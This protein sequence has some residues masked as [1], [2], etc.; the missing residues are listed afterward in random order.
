[1]HV[2]G[3]DPETHAGEHLPSEQPIKPAQALLWGLRRRRDEAQLTQAVAEVARA[4]RRFAGAFVELLLDTAEADANGRAVKRL[5]E[6][7]VAK[8]FGCRA[9]E[10]LRDTADITLGRVD[11]RFDGGDVTLFV[12]NK[13]YSGYGDAQVHRYLEALNKLPEDRRSALV[14]ITRQVPTY[15][16]PTL[17]ADERWLGSVRWARMLKG[18][19]RLPVGD[20]ALNEQW[21]S[22]LDILDQ[23]GDLG[24]TGADPTLIQAWARY[25]EGRRHLED[26]LDQV[27]PRAFEVISR[28]LKAKYGRKAKGAE[29]AVLYSRGKKRQV[30]Q[31]D[32]TRVFF[33]CCIPAVVKDPVLIIQFSGYFG[34]PHFTVQVEPWDAERRLTDRQDPKLTKASKALQSLG[35]QTNGRYWARVHEPDEYLSADDLPARVLKLIEEDVPPIVTSG[36]LDQDVEQ[37]LNRS[38]SGPPRHKSAPAPL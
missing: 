1:M 38:R 27:W 12:E 14:A 28:Q 3:S 16:E 9:E 7:P 33:G 29:L 25:L 18:L 24:M 19:R 4:D 36:I 26:I 11:L 30:I 37:T 17:E 35:F 5:R 8:E 31:R 2:S 20:T 10:H 34:V 15:G 32:Q 6:R 21:Q 13:L 22:F 23:Q